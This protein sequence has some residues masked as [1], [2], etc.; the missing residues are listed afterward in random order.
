MNSP[1]AE[2]ILRSMRRMIRSIDLHN[3]DLAAKSKLTAPQHVCLRQLCK[4]GPLCPSNLA[5]LVFL[6]QATVTGIIDRLE[7]RGLVQRQRSHPDRRRVTVSLTEAGRDLAETMPPPLHEGF[8]GRLEGLSLDEQ[9][10]IDGVLG[11]IVDMMEAGR[12]VKNGAGSRVYEPAALDRQLVEGL[13]KAAG[14]AGVL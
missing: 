7:A 9:A 4:D 13:P 3:Q 2:N 14:G 11:R 10:E 6:S 1:Y 12:R 5:R 8:A